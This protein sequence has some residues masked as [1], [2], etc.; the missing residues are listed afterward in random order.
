MHHVFFSFH[1]SSGVSY[2]PPSPRSLRRTKALLQSA[3]P[4]LQKSKN[5]PNNECKSPEKLTTLVATLS[6]DRA[7]L[8]EAIT[9]IGKGILVAF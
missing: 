4:P 9:T 3:K 2:P 5:V 1:F 8:G 7:G 6:V